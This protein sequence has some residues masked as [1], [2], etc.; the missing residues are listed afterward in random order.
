MRTKYNQNGSSSNSDLDNVVFPYSQGI[1][2][3]RE[4]SLELPEVVIVPPPK[5][6]LIKTIDVDSEKSGQVVPEKKD[7][8]RI[9]NKLESKINNNIQIMGY[10]YHFFKFNETFRNQ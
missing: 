7:I 4:P 10:F 9:M 8:E 5:K 2:E 3:K 6:V 1:I